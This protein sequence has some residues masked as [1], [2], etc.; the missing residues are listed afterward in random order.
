MAPSEGKVCDSINIVFIYAFTLT[1]PGRHK[2]PLSF[3][4]V[5]NQEF[6]PEGSNTE[7]TKE[8]KEKIISTVVKRESHF[9]SQDKASLVTIFGHASYSLSMSNLLCHKFLTTPISFMN[10]NSKREL[11][12]SK[13]F[14]TMACTESI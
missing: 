5:E 4:Y 3:F 11:N 13:I 6:M 14:V 12:G 2:E 1:V 9:S 7:N 10:I 8:E